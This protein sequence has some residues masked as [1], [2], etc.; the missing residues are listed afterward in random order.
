MIVS[1]A[2]PSS[3]K[4]TAVE[5]SSVHGKLI[6]LQCTSAYPSEFADG[7]CGS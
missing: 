6:L 5:R 3:T 4:S 2:W 1:T 7:T